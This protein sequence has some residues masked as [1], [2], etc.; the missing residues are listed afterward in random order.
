MSAADPAPGWYDD[1]VTPDVQ[2]WFDGTGWTE[3]TRPLPEA[4]LHAPQQGV[5]A[6]SGALAPTGASAP[7]APSWAPASGAAWLPG[8]PE[9]GAV[10]LDEEIAALAA[11]PAPSSGSMGGDP[12]FSSYGGGAQAGLGGGMGG[13]M[14]GVPTPVSA[15]WSSPTAA[16]PWS[17]Q[18]EPVGSPAH[19]GWRVL[20]TTLDEIIVT[21]PYLV[22]LFYALSTGTVVLD[23]RGQVAGVGD[24]TAALVV[25][26]GAA[27]LPVLWFVNRVV[28]QGRTG[29]S[30]GKRITGLRAVGEQTDEPIGMW[31]ALVR[32]VAHV[33]N[34]VLF[35][36]GYL[37]P[38]WDARRQAFSDKLTHT[39]VLRDP[40]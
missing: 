12:R 7:A 19:W 13:V 17:Q 11:A 37:W 31:W 10:P 35:Y 27:L 36:L 16:Q 33:V 1:G 29:Q 21:A 15:P 6:T 38:L 8:E 30:W 24:P 28:L 23:D 5:F 20:A 2:R 34:A 26:A 18:W 40:R 25:L 32:D 9:P 22:G 3:H 39:V 4:A 14:G